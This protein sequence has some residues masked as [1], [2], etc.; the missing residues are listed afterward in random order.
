MYVTNKFFWERKQSEK[1]SVEGLA[2][3]SKH[4]FEKR[5]ASCFTNQLINLLQELNVNEIELVGVDGNYCVLASA[6]AGKKSGFNILFNETCIGVSKPLKFK[7]TR[8]LL[9]NC[10]IAFTS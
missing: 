10:G 6:L 1:K 5:K 3:V 9:A 7:K 2:I 8:N 4:I